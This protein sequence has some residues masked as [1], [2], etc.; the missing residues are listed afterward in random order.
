MADQA[1]NGVFNAQPTAPVTPEAT[2]VSNDWIGEGR[3]YSNEQEALASIPNAQNHISKIEQENLDLRTQLDEAKTN[4]T[5]MDT[6]LGALQTTQQPTPAPVTADGSEED[7][8]SKIN[9]V[10]DNRSVVER[11]NSNLA[12]ADQLAQQAFGENAANEVA[13]KAGELGLTVGYLA[14]VAKNSPSAFSKMM[15]LGQTPVV[16]QPRGS[17]LSSST[18]NTEVLHSG[19]KVKDSSYYNEMRKSNPNQYK[20]LATQQEMMSSRSTLGSRFFNK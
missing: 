11:H 1:T 20:L 16:E 4:A 14:E 5:S 19:S 2:P 3:K 10:V 12:Q 17:S 18:V 15:G 7:L 9:Q 6:V 13:K 8:I